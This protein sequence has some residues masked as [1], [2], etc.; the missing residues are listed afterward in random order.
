MVEISEV[1]VCVWVVVPL[2]NFMEFFPFSQ[3]FIFWKCPADRLHFTFI[4]LLKE[5]Y[6]VHPSLSFSFLFS[7][8]SLKSM[9]FK[10]MK[11]Q[12]CHAHVRIYHGQWRS[13]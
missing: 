11:I 6:L 7:L 1:F 12:Y 9:D 3:V 8:N 13:A 4:I 2:L 5:A 10:E